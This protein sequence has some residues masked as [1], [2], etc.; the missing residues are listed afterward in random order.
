MSLWR[1]SR[2]LA[3]AVVACVLQC[4]GND[5][6]G[7]TGT[8]VKEDPSLAADIQPIFTRS[9]AL[10]SCHASPGQSGLVLEVGQSYAALVDIA[11]VQEPALK[12][13]EAF[14]PDESYLVT[15]L[16]G[17]QTVG[18]RMPPVGSLPSNEIRLIRN[19]I[20]KGATDN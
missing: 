8:A 1:R 4:C 5:D 7:S 9:C 18:T 12:R 13:V 2:T 11:S 20:A 6:G 17:R 16:E 19:W 15:K 10:S 14:L 3:A